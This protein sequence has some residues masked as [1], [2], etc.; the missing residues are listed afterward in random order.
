M[1]DRLAGDLLEAL[2]PRGDRMGPTYERGHRPVGR[3]CGELH[4]SG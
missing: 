3:R 2:E 4:G 1:K